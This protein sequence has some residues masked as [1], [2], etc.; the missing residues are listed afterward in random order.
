MRNS[1]FRA[2]IHR[3]QRGLSLI[4]ALLALVALTLGA[5][6][7]VRS[8]D[9]GVLTLGNLSW[10]QAALAAAG[11]GAEDAI[12]W[13]EGANAANKL[14]ANDLGNAYYASAMPTLDVTGK[15]ATSS[16]A[17]ELVRVDWEGDGKCLVDGVDYPSASCIPAS[18]EK[19]YGDV[20]VRYVIHRLCEN[21]GVPGEF[22]TC[23][24]PMIQG[25]ATVKSTANN[26]GLGQEPV[27]PP[28]DPGPYY[29]ITV[30]AEGVRKTVAFTE[31]LVNF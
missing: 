17:S 1:K 8:V 7:L 23:A 12:Q 24:K 13:L 21:V 20:K 27:N 22:N 31:T 2:T 3:G 10:K 6:A 29:R 19:T 15:G 25:Q 5:V 30:R 9:S 28:I 4:F 11:R 16:K 14:G 18:A 26:T